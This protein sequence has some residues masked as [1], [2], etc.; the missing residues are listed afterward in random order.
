MHFSIEQDDNVV[1]FTLREP[2]LDVQV[3]G[4]VKAEFLILCQPDVEALIVNLAEVKYCDSTGLSAL[5]L[6]HRQMREYG[7]PVVLVGVNPTVLNMLKI[8]QLDRVYPMFDTV[9]EALADLQE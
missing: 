6:A 8:S 7:A 3:A 2:R 9:E 5:L 4:D 1:I